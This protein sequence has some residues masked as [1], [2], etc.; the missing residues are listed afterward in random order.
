[1]KIRQTLA[2]LVC[3]SCF[4]TLAHA[5][6]APT[7]PT[8]VASPADLVRQWQTDQKEFRDLAVKFTNPVT[9]ADLVNK[10]TKAVRS[11]GMPPPTISTSRASANPGSSFIVNSVTVHFGRT[12]LNTL[13]SFVASIQIDAPKIIID[14]LVVAPERTTTL[15]TGDIRIFAI[16]FNSG[17]TDS[18]PPSDGTAQGDAD[19]TMAIAAKEALLAKFRAFAGQTLRPFEMLAAINP[20]LPADISFTKTR[21]YDG[22]KV[23][24]DCMATSS[25]AVTQY[26]D[27]LSTSSI[28]DLDKSN[29]S[30]Q[31]NPLVSPPQYK[32]ILYLTF[33]SGLGI[34]R[35]ALPGFSGAPSPKMVSTIAPLHPEKP[36]MILVV[37]LAG[38]AILLL[39]GGVIW[40]V[41]RK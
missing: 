21:F 22:N 27:A 41:R 20:F 6:A 18:V 15:Q 25:M 1:M 14:E 38:P 13:T 7:S 29:L 12:P 23:Q 10:V 39:V 32:F 36:S 8:A 17:A 5:A 28:V 9:V 33:R 3:G 2:Q 34:A 24:I 16:D 31:A 35:A 40:L 4:A 11:A 26:I 30:I 19:Q 37:G